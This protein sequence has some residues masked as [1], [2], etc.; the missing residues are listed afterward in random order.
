MSKKKNKNLSDQHRKNGFDPKPNNDK[1]TRIVAWVLILLIGFCTVCSFLTLGLTFKDCVQAKAEGTTVDAFVTAPLSFS[2][3]C[4]ARYTIA[5]VPNPS[6]VDDFGENSFSVNI[7]ETD[8]TFSFS[9]DVSY[10]VKQLKFSGSYVYQNAFVYPVVNGSYYLWFN[11]NK[12]PV[13]TY[14]KNANFTYFTVADYAKSLPDYY[15]GDLVNNVTFY[16]EVS[17]SGLSN[18][19]QITYLL[20]SYQTPQTLKESYKYTNENGDYLEIYCYRYGYAGNSFV[21]VT[22]TRYLAALDYSNGYDTGYSEGYEAGKTVSDD[23]VYQNGFNVGKGQGYSQ[24]YNAGLEASN[25]YTFLNL[26]ASVIDAPIQAVA[27]LLNFNLLGFNMLNFF[28]ALLTLAI[29]VAVVRL[30]L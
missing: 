20:D 28:Y 25:K 12:M 7:A 19:S 13:Y 22:W 16:Y 21:P 24:G 9:Y 5:K 15:G 6:S 8:Y 3:A 1:R 2:P 18:Y 17:S 29:I 14:L 27:G 10:G 23:N 26:M 4:T 30:I 11:A